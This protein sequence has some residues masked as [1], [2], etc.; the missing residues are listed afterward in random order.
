MMSTDELQDTYEGKKVYTISI[1]KANL[2]ALIMIIPILAILGLPY[3]LIWGGG[4]MDQI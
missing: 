3:Y 2:V 1:A 4:I